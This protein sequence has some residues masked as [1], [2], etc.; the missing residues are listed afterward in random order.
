MTYTIRAGERILSFETPK[1][2]GVI[3][4]NED[5]FYQTSRATTIKDILSKAEK[6]LLEGA[7]IIDIGA[8]S[9]RPGAQ[10]SNAKEEAEL[11]SK[12]CKTVSKEFNCILSVDTVHSQVAQECF[13]NG[14]L[15]INDIS[16]GT[17]DQN[18]FSIVA[19][20]KTPYI[21][22][23]MIGTPETMQK[24]TNYNNVTLE[25][26]QHLSK[27]IAKFM[28]AGGG[29]LIIDPGF[30]FSKDIHQNYQMLDQ[31]HLFAMLQ[32]PILVGL[33]RKSMI[34]KLLNIS[35]EEALNGTTV[36]HT[37]ALIKGA[38]ILRVHDVKEAQECI[39][40]VSTLNSSHTVS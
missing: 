39:E 5:S 28:E 34:Y 33:S 21:G 10:L 40:L 13:D 1:I 32:K 35:S 6:H 27:Q 8:M 37:I 11:L 3:N 12:I 22:M 16:F 25:V 20:L 30:G 14:A 19:N 15:I 23:H 31:L 9:S 7:D 2:M 4:I 18:M 26:I 36:L 29:D 24:N 17:I 38:Q